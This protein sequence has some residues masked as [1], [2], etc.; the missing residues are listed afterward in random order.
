MATKQEV[1]DYINT[2]NIEDVLT[3]IEIAHLQERIDPY[4]AQI[5]IK[6]VG[7]VSWLVE[8]RDNV[9][10]DQTNRNL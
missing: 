3:D 5:L 6:V 2:G 8:I 10:R 9:S 4:L 1:A 7:D